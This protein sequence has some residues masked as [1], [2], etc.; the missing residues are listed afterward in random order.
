MARVILLLRLNAIKGCF[1]DGLRGSVVGQLSE[2]FDAFGFAGSDQQLISTFEFSGTA[3][4]LNLVIPDDR[5]SNQL[6][7]AL[8]HFGYPLVGEL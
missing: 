7:K 8:E 4:Q 1:R 6:G 3:R 2:S 5:H